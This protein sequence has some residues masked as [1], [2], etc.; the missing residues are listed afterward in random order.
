M[1]K[2]GAYEIYI[3]RM[4]KNPKTKPVFEEY[5]SLTGKYPPFYLDNPSEEEIIEDV[6]HGVEL[7]KKRKAK[8]AASH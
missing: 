4:L 8:N 5:H 6:K 3:E 7:A 2:P 1:L